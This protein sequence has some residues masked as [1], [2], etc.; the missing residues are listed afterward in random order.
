[1]NCLVRPAKLVF[2]LPKKEKWK[3]QPGSIFWNFLLDFDY[4]LGFIK[5]INMYEIFG[6][7]LIIL[8]INEFN[9]VCD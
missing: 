4:N 6:F 1:M 7:D 2:S 8:K 5:N 9:F 3:K